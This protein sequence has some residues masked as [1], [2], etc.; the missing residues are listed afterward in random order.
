MAD[1]INLVRYE[2]NIIELELKD[3]DQ[4]IAN[5]IAKYAIKRPDVAYSSYI[6][7]HPLKKDI[8]IV[9]TTSNG[10]DPLQVVKEILENIINDA[11]TFLS[12][13]ENVVEKG[14]ACEERE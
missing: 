7:P 12:L 10:K 6:V 8:K 2:K 13:F 4:T 3:G 11:N 1:I 5:L 9:I 14:G